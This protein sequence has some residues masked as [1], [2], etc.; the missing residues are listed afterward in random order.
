MLQN[1]R[2]RKR[3]CDEI[4]L[5]HAKQDPTSKKQKTDDMNDDSDIDDDAGCMVDLEDH[6]DMKKGLKLKANKS[7]REH[8]RKY[9]E[10]EDKCNKL[11]LKYNDLD[12][13]YQDV[14]SKLSIDLE[15]IELASLKHERLIELEHQITQKYHNHQSNFDRIM[16]QINA[17]KHKLA[18]ERLAKTLC[19]KCKKNERNIMIQ[20]CNHVVSCQCC[21]K[22]M[23]NQVC[24]ACK[25][26]YA[27]VVL[28]KYYFF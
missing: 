23:E 8:R 10:L 20:G 4:T 14:K 15:N 21:E 11:N 25:K 19:V 3:K 24:S 28:V 16:K 26:S 9:N 18:K 17:A 22:R 6:E 12:S 7:D 27:N 2:S 1:R 13:K 5:H